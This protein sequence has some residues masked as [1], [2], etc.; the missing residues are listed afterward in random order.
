MDKDQG[1]L[2]TTRIREEEVVREIS[3]RAELMC[4]KL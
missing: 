2:S 4:R 3:I 1:S